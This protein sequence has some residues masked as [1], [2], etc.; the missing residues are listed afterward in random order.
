[1]DDIEDVEDDSRSE[2]DKGKDDVESL[3]ELECQRMLCYCISD[4]HAIIVAATPYLFL[5]R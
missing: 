4:F 3:F 5:E 1:M 2:Y